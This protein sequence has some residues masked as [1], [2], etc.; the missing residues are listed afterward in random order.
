MGIYSDLLFHQGHIAD[1]ALARALATTPKA[2]TPPAPD[3]A[4]RVA[5][6]DAQATEEKNREYA[7]LRRRMTALSPFR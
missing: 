3:T 1:L 7:L 5:A 6:A 2:P 4:T